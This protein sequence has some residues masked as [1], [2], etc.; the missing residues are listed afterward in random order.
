MDENCLKRIFP[1]I[2]NSRSEFMA[3]SK[4]WKNPFGILQ[5]AKQG[6]DLQIRRI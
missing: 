3:S 1:E 6:E 4:V 5:L 2:L